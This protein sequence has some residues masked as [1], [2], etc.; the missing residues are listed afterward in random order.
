MEKWHDREELHKLTGS[1]KET[2]ASGLPL[3]WEAVEYVLQQ[4][5]VEKDKGLHGVA[6][7]YAA[8]YLLRLGKTED[9]LAYLNESVSCIM[10]TEHETQ[11]RHCYNMLG[12][13]AHGQDD[14]VLAMEYYYKAYAYADRFEDHMG[15]CIVLSNMADVFFRVG[16]YEKANQCYA[17]CIQKYEE[18]GSNTVQDDSNYC[19]MLA[20]YGYCLLELDKL[21]EAM[22]VAK[23]L[24]NLTERLQDQTPWLA[25]YTFY[26]Y[27]GHQYHKTEISIEYMQKAMKFLEGR[28]STDYDNILNLIHLLIKAKCFADLGAVLDRLE[29]E[30]AAE[31]N[32]GL[33]MQLLVYRL[34]YCSANMS[35]EEYLK[36]TENF[37]NIKDIFEEKKNKQIMRTMTL[38]NRLRE[39]EEEQEELKKKNVQLQYQAEY[40]AVSGLHNRR[41]LNR[42]MEECFDFAMKQGE[43]LGIAFVDIDYFKE[44]NDFYG[45]QRGDECIA[46]IAG[47]IKECMPEDYIARYGGDE[48]VA[49][50]HG[51]TQELFA[52]KLRRIEESVRKLQIA[53]EDAPYEQV[54][55]ITVGAIHA[56]P[57]KP[58]KIW[59]YMATADE[60]LYR[61]KKEQ[62]GK[63][64]ISYKLGEY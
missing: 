24:K 46:A 50:T 26:A 2:I 16:A 14:L 33:L 38:R 35:P 6:C 37:F 21:E 25:V 56:K 11:A 48:F 15:H 20:G 18:Y 28:I 5:P 7:Y 29:P 36:Y 49:I 8:Y 45:H 9:A 31:H 3:T 53:N 30:A 57:H 13:I 63:V 42:R 32:D 64:R 43:N 41:H 22:T 52:E 60:V 54:L 39:I 23:R 27:L 58:N 55:T 47:A 4:I 40:D 10:G 62:K 17:E 51:D 12:I 19:I 59:D 44:M 1:L 34:K 61:Q